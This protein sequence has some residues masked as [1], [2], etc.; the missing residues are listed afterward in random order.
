ML[1]GDLN[2]IGPILDFGWQNKKN[3]ATGISSGLIDTIYEAAMKAG[4]T[5]GKVSGAGGGGFMFFYCPGNTR[6]SVIETLLTFGGQ[7]KNFNFSKN[8]LTSWTI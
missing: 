3:M 4:S 2:E 1:K 6:F 5:G 8:G 7:I